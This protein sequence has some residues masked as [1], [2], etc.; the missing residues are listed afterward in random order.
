[1]T[2]R[3]DINNLRKLAN[4]VIS[5]INGVNNITEVKDFNLLN[6]LNNGKNNQ[7]NKILITPENRVFS[8]GK[9]KKIYYSNEID[10]GLENLTFS[11]YGLHSEITSIEYINS[12]V[13]FVG[14]LNG[15][16]WYLSIDEKIKTKIFPKR[17]N[18]NSLPIS[19]L[20]YLNQ[21]IYSLLE[22]LLIEYDLNTR[23]L[24]EVIIGERNKERLVEF[25]F[26]EKNN[27]Y[28]LTYEG[29][30]IE[31]DINK[32]THRQ[33]FRSKNDILSYNDKVTKVDFFENKFIFSTLN[34][35]IYIFDQDNRELKFKQRILAH[36][37]EIVSLYYDKELNKLFSSSSQGTFCI[38]D[39]NFDQNTPQ[40]R[41]DIDFGVNSIITDVKSLNIEDKKFII[42][43]NSQGNLSLLNLELNEVYNYIRK[44]INN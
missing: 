23:V 20:L 36:N 7:L 43:S 17:K 42:M 14:L 2:E 5:K 24:T 39:I 16:I 21:K 34:G 15:E 8:A 29:N 41:I 18:K 37:S 13:L 26:D 30:I 44:F 3:N 9:S 4:N 11:E 6:E 27:L 19:S 22:N 40:S 38:I 31:Y 35:W 12:D 33:I 32:R 28:I 1:M 25:T 10:K